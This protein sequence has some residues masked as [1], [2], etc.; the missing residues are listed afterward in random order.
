[1]YSVSQQFKDA[2]EASA[3][4]HIFGSIT[5]IN[6]N[7]ISLNTNGNENILGTPVISTQIVSDAD[8]FNV[9]ELYIGDL[10]IE[11]KLSVSEVELEAAEIELYVTID[12]A[13]DEVPMGIWDIN[14]AKKQPSGAIKITAYDRIA[15][16]TAPIPASDGAGMIRFADV[17][18]YIEEL[19]GIEFAQSVADLQVLCPDVYLS[20]GY[21]FSTSYAPTCWLEVQY[22]AQYLGCYVIANR[23]GEIEFRRFA[24][25][26]VK[27]ITADRRFNIDLSCGMYYVKGFGYT[28][29]Y[30]KTVTKTH[31][32]VG[33]TSSMIYLPQENPFVWDYEDE[34]AADREYGEILER[35]AD[36][37]KMSVEM[38]SSWY[39]GTVDFY[40][41]PTLD[42]GDMVALT[43]GIN[44][45]HTAYFLICHNTWQFR[46][47]QTLISGGAPRA[48]STVSASGG[49]SGNI[50]NST[51]MNITKNIILAKFTGFTGQLVSD[52]P[53][54]AARCRFSAKEQT[55]AFITC[56]MTFTGSASAQ[57]LRNNI[58]MDI[59]PTG[60]GTLSFTLPFT[61]DGGVHDIRIRLSGNG[62]LTAVQ[63]AV[64]G[65]NITAQDLTYTEWEYEIEDDSVVITGYSGTDTVIEI[66][67]ELGGKQVVKIADGT[68]TENDD[69]IA[70]YIPDGI[71]T[72]E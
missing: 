54:T 30:G 12:G 29:K 58:P 65:Q 6:G 67:P 62:E 39:S 24:L 7:T 45:I 32:G 50:Y 47:P 41:D 31:G 35:L 71:E 48:G 51:V 53:K 19:S 15:K 38:V 52:I 63:G 11:V 46:G 9:G 43:G 20:G 49:G 66:P 16:L 42:A 57:I 27:T 3:K 22:I 60:T 26:S 68:F 17:L 72:I 40:G 36:L 25:Q 34:T 28:D 18:A 37:F 8:V 55:A 59:E 13:V 33:T 70:V 4:Q 44:G 1:M 21:P 23:D 5:L 64:W 10:E 69:I 56:T 14:E 61:A 2:L